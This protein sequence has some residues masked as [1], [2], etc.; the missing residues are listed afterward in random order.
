[1]LPM[2]LFNYFLNR[3]LAHVKRFNNRPLL[4]PESVAEH[5]FYTAH[6]TQI[7]CWLLSNKKIKVDSQ[8]AISM[9][10]IHDSEEGFSGDILNPFKHFNDKIASAI[11][12]V[13]EET[14]GLMF[15]ELP[16]ELS[17]DLIDL[18]HEEQKRGSIESQVVKLADSLSLISKCFEEIEA[19]NSN[20]HEIYRK[21]IKNVSALKYPWFAKIK[22]EI[23]A[24]I[25]KQI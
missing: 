18:W 22:A 2:S 16:K 24:G 7:I 8:K 15:E 3:N 19:G 21:E 14:V 10:L 1:M 23:L 13:N 11:R 9:A 20:F 4:F 25:S 6:F 12:E 5:S 17:S